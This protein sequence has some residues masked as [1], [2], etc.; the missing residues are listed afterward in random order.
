MARARQRAEWERTAEVLAMQYNMLRDSAKSRSR[1]ADDFNPYRTH[2]KPKPL[3]T[4][5]NM[6]ILRVFVDGQVP[7]EVISAAAERK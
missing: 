5:A 4:T 3:F 2:T 1:S 6:E 7:P